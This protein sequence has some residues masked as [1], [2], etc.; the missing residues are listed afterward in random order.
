MLAK[1]QMTN[2]VVIEPGEY[3]SFRMDYRPLVIG[4]DFE[5][6]AAPADRLADA[7]APSWVYLV[8]LA[9]I[10]FSGLF[11]GAYILWHKEFDRDRAIRWI[12]RNFFLLWVGFVVVYFPL[13]LVPLVLST[14][15][16][17]LFV[18]LYKLVRGLSSHVRRIRVGKK[19]R[20]SEK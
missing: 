2:L 7:T 13:S 9:V 6:A 19:N 10:V 18:A 15:I 16:G 1:S 17:L 8:F 11:L 3:K 4:S 12:P 20:E 5:F 14:G